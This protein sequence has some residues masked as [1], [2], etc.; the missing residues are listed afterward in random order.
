MRRRETAPLRHKHEM[1]WVSEEAARVG[2][3]SS[4]HRVSSVNADWFRP[5]PGC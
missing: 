1:P 4:L 3:P 5:L 2:R